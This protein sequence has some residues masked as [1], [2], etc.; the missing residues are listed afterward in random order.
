VLG[1]TLPAVARRIQRQARGREHRQAVHGEGY[2]D[3]GQAGRNRQASRICRPIWAPTRYLGII[4]IRT[5]SSKTASAPSAKSRRSQ[6][7]SIPAG[8][9]ALQR[10]DARDGESDSSAARLKIPRLL[11]QG[12]RGLAFRTE[13]GASRASPTQ[14][15]REDGTLDK[16]FKAWWNEH[17]ERY[18]RVE[19]GAPRRRNDTPACR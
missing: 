14:T 15:S 12:R 4:K 11:R 1:E 5:T 18:R 10:P 16:S 9:R 3:A 7:A 17:G 6:K 13:M 8:C 2:G 19:K